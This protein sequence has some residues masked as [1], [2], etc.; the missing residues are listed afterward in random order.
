LET[1]GVFVHLEKWFAV[2]LEKRAEDD[3]VFRA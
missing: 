1:D 3:V 2:A